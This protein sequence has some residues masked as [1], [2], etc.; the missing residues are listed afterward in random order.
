MKR[1][2]Q[3][4]KFYIGRIYKNLLRFFRWTVFSVITG[5]VVGAFSTAFVLAFDW[6]IDMR[7]AHRWLLY[8]LPVAGCIIVAL[9]GVFKYKNDRG[10]NLVLSTIHSQDEIPFKMAPLIFISTLLTHLCGGSSGREGAALQLGGSLGNTLGRFFKFDE[11]DKHV[12]VMCGMSAAF[13]VMFGT[14]IAAVI[15]SMEV[16]SVGLMYYAALVPC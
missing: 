16:V 9:Y 10:T 12:V 13:A 11:K 6:C 2:I 5:A 8:F 15:F 7:N 14:P 3:L 1:K 4:I